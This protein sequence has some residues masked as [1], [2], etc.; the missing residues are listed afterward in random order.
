MK[1]KPLSQ[2]EGYIQVIR[3]EIDETIDQD[4]RFDI[5]RQMAAGMLG[6]SRLGGYKNDEKCAASEADLAEAA[7]ILADALLA[8]RA[9]R[10]D[11]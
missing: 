3:G 7:Y 8:E 2:T 10:E 9:K 1:K 6:N 11:V 4:L 5:A